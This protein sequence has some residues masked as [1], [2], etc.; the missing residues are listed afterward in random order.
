MQNER[1]THKIMLELNYATISSKELSKLERILLSYR[2]EDFGAILT[3]GVL[4]VNK[5]LKKPKKLEKIVRRMFAVDHLLEGESSDL[6][7]A[8][9]LEVRDTWG[10]SLW[11]QIYRAWS[12][13]LGAKLKAED[14]S[15]AAAWLELYGDV[16]YTDSI[17]DLLPGFRSGVLE[18]IYS[19]S[20]NIRDIFNYGFQMGVQYGT[21]AVTA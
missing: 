8:L 15:A 21:K 11:R 18:A 10:E 1:G 4:K 3:D 9:Y 13:T 17:D 7:D 16:S 19:S 20:R 14:Q 2:G 6:F 12:D 5:D